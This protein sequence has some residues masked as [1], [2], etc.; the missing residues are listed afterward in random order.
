[1]FEGLMASLTQYYITFKWIFRRI[2]NKMWAGISLSDVATLQHSI[3]HYVA[4]GMHVYRYN[5]QGFSKHTY[6]STH[7]V[8]QASKMYIVQ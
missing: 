1:M 6:V 2:C 7:S 8:T 5:L 3:T 4:I